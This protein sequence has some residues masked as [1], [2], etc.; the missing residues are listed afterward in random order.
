MRKCPITCLPT[1]TPRPKRGKPTGA[2]VSDASA[3]KAAVR[4]QKDQAKR[5]RQRLREEAAAA[6]RRERREAAVTNAEAAI[7]DARQDH[8]RKQGAIDAERSILEKRSEAED[9]RWTKLKQKLQAALRR[10]RAL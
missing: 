1:A 2:K 10:A 6:R 8:E 3:R 7:A 5:E 9:E 4:Y